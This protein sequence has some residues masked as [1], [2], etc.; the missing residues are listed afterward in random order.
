MPSA[1][2][3]IGDLADDLYICTQTCMP[4]DQQLHPHAVL[5][6]SITPG[7]AYVTED[8][9]QATLSNSRT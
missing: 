3:D 6:S 9:A 2:I 5:S 8:P 4:P 1:F 7:D